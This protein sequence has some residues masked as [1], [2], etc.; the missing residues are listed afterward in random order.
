MASTKCEERV[1]LY[2]PPELLD[3]VVGF[4][5]KLDLSTCTLLSRRWYSSA[6][7]RLFRAV[8]IHDHAQPSDFLPHPD[9]ICKCGSARDYNLTAFN[10]FLQDNFDAD[11]ARCINELSIKGGHP[12]VPMR[13]TVDDIRALLAR[14]PSLDSLSLIDI[15]LSPGPDVEPTIVLE[16]RPLSTLS[17]NN[18]HVPPGPPPRDRRLVVLPVGSPIDLL[19]LFS[20]VEV[21][22]VADIKFG[23][24]IEGPQGFPAHIL[25]FFA[26]QASR[27]P[28]GF[29]ITELSVSHGQHQPSQTVLLYLLNSST[30]LSALRSL[31]VRDERPGTLRTLLENIGC[32]LQSLHIDLEGQPAGITHKVRFHRR[33]FRRLDAHRRSRTSTAFPTVLLYGIFA[34]PCTRWAS[35][36]T[37]WTR[38]LSFIYPIS[39]I[40]CLP[41]FKT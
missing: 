4:L 5:D 9:S 28:S 24:W 14:L 21:L 37:Y 29:R 11:I 36:T 22:R 16:P 8:F 26:E 7:P 13:C 12:Q 32:S 33:S 38:N 1:E 19:R 6:R 30:S 40:V 31:D 39:W 20:S 2:L 23:G 34:S 35:I 3:N 41:Q 18:I 27:I 25:Q 10:A 15:I 17:L